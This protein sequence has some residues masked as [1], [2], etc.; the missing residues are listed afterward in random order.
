MIDLISDD[1]TMESRKGM[2]AIIQP[3]ALGGWGEG[4]KLMMVGNNRRRSDNKSGFD[5]QEVHDAFAGGER[6]R[7]GGWED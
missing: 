6:R 7:G 2:H 3:G 4:I 5:E 1:T